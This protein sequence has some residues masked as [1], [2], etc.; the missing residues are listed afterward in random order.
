VDQL[1]CLAGLRQVIAFSTS[2]VAFVLLPQPQHETTL[3]SSAAGFVRRWGDVVHVT[4]HPISTHGSC[5]NQ[6]VQMIK[7]PP[8]GKCRRFDDFTGDL[9]EYDVTNPRGPLSSYWESQG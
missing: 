6:P 3:M 4:V 1:R 2:H 9:G 5:D 7:Q 8:R